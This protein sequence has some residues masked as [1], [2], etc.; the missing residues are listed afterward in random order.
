M[1]SRID[2]MAASSS[3][4]HQMEI[5]PVQYDEIIKRKAVP[6]NFFLRIGGVINYGV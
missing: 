1:A 4:K 6:G 5:P 2:I 3:D